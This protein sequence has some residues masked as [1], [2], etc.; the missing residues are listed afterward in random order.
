MSSVIFLQ[1]N[2][3]LSP[4]HI[5]FNKLVSSI[6]KLRE[7]LDAEEKRLEL[8]SDFHIKNI[9]TLEVDQAQLQ[10]EMAHKLDDFSVS[11]TL[12]K[13]VVD[14]LEILI[15][16]LLAKSF[17][18]V[19]PDDKS[20]AIYQKWTELDLDDLRKA[21]KDENRK[22]LVDYLRSMGVD[23]N[24]DDIDFDDPASEEKLHQRIYE[25][26]EQLD[27]RKADAKAN[28]KQSKKE[29]EAEE[30]AKLHDELKNK[31][32]R[33]V[34][35]SLAKILHPDTEIDPDIKLAKEEVMKQVTKA[36]EDKDIITLLVIETNWLKNTQERL[37]NINE[38]V[39]GVYILLLKEQA[40][41]LRQE[42]GEMRYHP[43]FQHIDR[44]VS[45]K[46]DHGLLLLS[47]FQ[48]KLKKDLRTSH[49]ELEIIKT[50]P[51]SDVKKMIRSMTKRY[52]ERY[53]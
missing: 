17:E 2:P 25:A 24:L 5:Q 14:D 45:M 15:P 1:T 4:K 28:K 37:S 36:Y 48:A 9:R 33:S 12:P 10:V 8:F 19:K 27:Q 20:K 52:C 32:L 21:E 51:R 16:A 46:T 18:F 44:Y 50:S 42:K 43:R 11:S 31:N 47:S 23:I 40:K 29:I 39:A 38:E 34:Y 7:E 35:L 49:R 53:L 30:L 13:N 3:D 22:E 6:A 41:K 26:K